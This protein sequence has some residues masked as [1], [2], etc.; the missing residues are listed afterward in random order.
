MLLAWSESWSG[1]RCWLS[2]RAT[3]RP[4]APSL[5]HLRGG[6]L[7][8]SGPA[9]ADLMRTVL[10]RGRSFRFCARGWSMS[11]FVKDGDVITVAPAQP[12]NQSPGRD[13]SP[14]VPRGEAPDTGT[15]GI[16]QVVAF[17]RPE[18]QRLVVHRVIGRHESRLLIQGDNLSGLGPDAVSLDDIVGRVVRIERGSKRVWLGLG[19][20]RYAIAALSR[21]G[22][23]LPVL[24]RASLLTRF[25]KRRHNEDN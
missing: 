20:E 11:P 12:R 14:S 16:G 7:R 6:E 1:G 22:F 5:R 8:L 15:C 23:L 24:L 4:E 9:L 21:A 3:D 13:R 17:I 19:P 25:L 18:T 10:A 2:N